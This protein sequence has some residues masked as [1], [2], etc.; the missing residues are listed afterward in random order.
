MQV[1]FLLACLNPTTCDI[2]SR[3]KV[4]CHLPYKFLCLLSIPKKPWFSISMDFIIDLP[5]SK[6]FYFFFVVVN[7][8]TKMAYFMQC[9]KLITCEETTRLFTDNIYKYHCLLDEII[10][11][12]GS[13]V[14]SKFLG[15]ITQYP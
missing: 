5:S 7:Q 12:C 4:P 10:S 3:S 15:I 13:Q 14:T 8:L 11:D 2:S 9:N 1:W 6:I